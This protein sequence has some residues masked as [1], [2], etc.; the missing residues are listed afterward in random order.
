MSTSTREKILGQL[1]TD[2]QALGWV[3]T[4]VVTREEVPL[5]WYRRSQLP[6]VELRPVEERV[7]PMSGLRE[8]NRLRLAVT[9]H[10]LDFGDEVDWE[11]YIEDVRETLAADY[12]AAGHAVNTNLVR[13]EYGGGFP[14]YRIALEYEVTYHADM[15]NV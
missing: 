8:R 11:Q 4:V 7:E 6:L 14:L 13:V 3:Q 2:L 9:V 12:R 5:V 15:T 1:A 10:Y